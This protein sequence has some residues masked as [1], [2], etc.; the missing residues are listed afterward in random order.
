MGYE[1]QLFEK[2][3]M[4]DRERK[5]LESEI[6]H[7]RSDMRMKTSGPRTKKYMQQKEHKF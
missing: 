3:Q 5:E 2:Q 6:D 4:M 7:E 1:L